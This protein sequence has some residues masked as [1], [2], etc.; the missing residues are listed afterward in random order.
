MNLGMQ[1]Y[2]LNYT[3]VPSLLT[4]RSQHM[5]LIAIKSK[6]KEI[7]LLYSSQGKF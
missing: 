6:E 7:L 3:S 5:I 1:Y 2:F 4:F